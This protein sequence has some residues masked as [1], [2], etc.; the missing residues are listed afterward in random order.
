MSDLQ[1][2]A[3][4]SS[5]V[6]PTLACATAGNALH[7]TKSIYGCVN[8]ILSAHVIPALAGVEA[9]IYGQKAGEI[10]GCFKAI[11]MPSALFT[12]NHPIL[13]LF[14]FILNNRNCIYIC[15]KPTF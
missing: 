11:A 1:A 13:H 2:S 14:Y 15:R 8:S 3:R 7:S 12:V 10:C 5:H 4:T 6:I 9:G